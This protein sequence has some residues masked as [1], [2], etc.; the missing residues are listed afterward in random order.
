MYNKRLYE[1]LLIYLEKHEW[2]GFETQYKGLK[3]FVNEKFPD[4]TIILPKRYET[5]DVSQRIDDSINTISLIT[6]EKKNLL[7]NS[8]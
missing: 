4:F 1:N 3:A 2:K 8:L 7:I 5:P 6:E